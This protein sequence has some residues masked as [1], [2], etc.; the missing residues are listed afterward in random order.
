MKSDP[1]PATNIYSYFTYSQIPVLNLSATI[2]GT[3]LQTSYINGV[4]GGINIS[5]VFFKGKVQ[6]GLGYRYVDNQIPENLT[7][8]RQHMAEFNFSWQFY[9][10]MILSMN[11]EGTFEDQY[12]YNMIYVQVRKRF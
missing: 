11:Y 10:K 9:K 12:S 6:T 8:L 2:T 5:R 7:D 1:H 4:V 3:Y